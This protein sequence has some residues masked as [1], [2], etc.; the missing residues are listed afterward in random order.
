MV[1]WVVCPSVWIM[2]ELTRVGAPPIVRLDTEP[3]HGGRPAPW[4]L[5]RAAPRD[6]RGHGL[7][8]DREV[9]EHRPTLEVEEV[10]PDEVVEVEARAAR[11]L[12]EA[13]DPRQHE[14]ALLVPVLEAVV[15]A[16]RQ[17]AGAHERHLPE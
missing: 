17:R 6:H 16:L 10:E 12:P 7:Q 5:E 14:V 13:G 1:K 9:E 2:G 8:E 4:R 15:V 3:R 11:D